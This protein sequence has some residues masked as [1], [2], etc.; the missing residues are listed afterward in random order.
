VESC[1]IIKMTINFHEFLDASNC[2]QIALHR[3]KR[4]SDGRVS[5]FFSRRTVIRIRVFAKRIKY[6][7]GN[8]ELALEQTKHDSREEC[9]GDFWEISLRSN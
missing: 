9:H 3:I 1:L 5:W 6:Y 8:F 4:E 2:F 7:L